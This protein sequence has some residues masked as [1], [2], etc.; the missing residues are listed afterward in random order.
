MSAEAP[1]GGTV[2]NV[3]PAQNQNY[4]TR[5]VFDATITPIQ[6]DV[7]EIKGDVKVLLARDAGSRALSGFV[8]KAATLATTVAAG[9]IGALIALFVH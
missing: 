1:S 5:D 7:S 9:G 8:S 6:A 2:V 3:Q 4:V